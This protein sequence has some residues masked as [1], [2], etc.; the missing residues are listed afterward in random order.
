MAAARQGVRSPP[1]RAC[2]RSGCS[3]RS[4]LERELPAEGSA[5]GARPPSV[6]GFRPPVAGVR[7]AA[8]AQRCTTASA[9]ERSVA[10]ACCGNHLGL[11]RA[12]PA[13]QRRQ[14]ALP[15]TAAIRC[16]LAAGS[17]AS[18]SKRRI[19][20]AQRTAASAA[21]PHRRVALRFP[22]TTHISGMRIDMRPRSRSSGAPV[23]R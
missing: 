17:A 4:R 9:D 2:T 20:S 16:A 13:R 14:R 18:F 10:V 11:I 7:R 6:P 19:G 5:S 15:I 21:A 8:S 22:H 3:S 23:R 12:L 1:R